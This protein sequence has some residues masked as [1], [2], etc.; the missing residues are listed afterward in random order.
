MNS[1]PQAAADDQE[2]G[3][4][5][6][7]VLGVDTHKEFHVAAVLTMLGSLVA[8]RCFPATA[9]GY[10]QLLAWAR[11]IGTVRSAGVECTGS[12]GA[13]LGRYLLC[14]GVK[15]FEVNQ[16]DRATR[17]RRGK[18]DEIDAEA[19]AA[20]VLSGRASAIAKAGNGPVEMLRI[21]RLAKSSAIKARTQTINQ[22]KAVLVSAATGLRESLAGLSTIKLVRRCADLDAEAST[23]LA[24]AAVFT[25]RLLARRFLELS[26][27]V[28][29]LERR[30]SEVV[31]RHRP[32]LLERRGVGP[33]N[34]AALL[35]AAGDNPERMRNEASFA[36]LCGTSPVS[37]SSGRTIRMRL[38]RGG[39]R[40]ANA[41]LYRITISLRWDPATREY[42]A[43]RIT[44][45][46]SR[47][48]AIRCLKRYVAREIYSIITGPPAGSAPPPS[49]T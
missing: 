8:T 48:E 12:Y 23:G 20:A 35:I 34:A 37:A 16:S 19:A 1:M 14:E 33:D 45:G 41:A 11:S 29:E 32:Q 26:T 43:R 10:E 4:E 40:Q 18:S 31:A 17:R 2:S 27:E 7:V 46:K 24:E 30:I 44:E 9:A 15:V 13:A 38:N 21:F 22:L 25:L 47:R 36:S 5:N 28:R 3:R 49:T 6:E 39:N 42:L